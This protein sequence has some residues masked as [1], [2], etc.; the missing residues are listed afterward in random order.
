MVEMVKPGFPFS[1]LVNRPSNSSHALAVAALFFATMAT[2]KLT[3]FYV[4]AWPWKNDS[5]SM[6]L[7]A[8]VLAL[9]AR[10]LRQPPE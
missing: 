8:L 5:L 7:C 10:A 4:L 6:L 9:V 1:N 3:Y 2:A